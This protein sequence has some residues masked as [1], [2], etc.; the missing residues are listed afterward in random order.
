MGS[1]ESHFNWA[2]KH[3]ITHATHSLTRT[4]LYICASVLKS[5]MVK[6][7]NWFKCIFPLSF[8][9][10][11]QIQMQLVVW[12]LGKH[13]KWCSSMHT[14]VICIHTCRHYQYHCHC[15]HRL[16]DA[17]AS[18]HLQNVRQLFQSLQL[19]TLPNAIELNGIY[20]LGMLSLNGIWLHTQMCYEMIWWPFYV[21]WPNDRLFVYYGIC[22]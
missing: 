16:S 6:S 5:Q 14:L 11:C 13:S 15:L 20:S 17:S 10:E 19:E 12:C 7:L 22:I 9:V 3:E 18:I 21:D 1:Q 4:I 2:I 8:R